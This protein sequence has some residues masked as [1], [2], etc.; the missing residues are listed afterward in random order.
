MR[1]FLRRP[2]R[3]LGQFQAVILSA[4]L[5]LAGVCCCLLADYQDYDALGLILFLRVDNTVC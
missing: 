1:S 5:G 4:A 2:S 3:L